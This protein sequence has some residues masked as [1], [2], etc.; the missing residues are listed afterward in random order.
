[1][2]QPDILEGSRHSHLTDLMWKLLQDR[3]P[4]DQNVPVCGFI[5]PCQQ[6]KTGGLAGPVGADNRHGLPFFYGEIEIMDRSQPAKRNTHASR[7]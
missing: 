5:D 7:L 4:A 2:E 1:M 3:R 6:I